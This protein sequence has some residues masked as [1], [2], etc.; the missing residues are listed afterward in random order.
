MFIK[1]GDSFHVRL[2]LALILVLGMIG[3]RPI[4]P[5]LAAT[6]LVTNTSDSGP[7][8]LRQAIASAGSGDTISF[9]S[10]LG[11]YSIIDLFSPLVIDKNLTIDASNLA[12]PLPID[13]RSGSNI[14]VLSSTVTILNLVIQRGYNNGNGE[15]SGPTEI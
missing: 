1:A 13:L 11:A 15:P 2:A 3:I 9:D 5:V 7:G 4:Q 6:L 12:N 10:S 14:Q 8:S